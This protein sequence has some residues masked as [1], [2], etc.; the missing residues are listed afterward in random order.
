MHMQVSNIK[1]TTTWGWGSHFEERKWGM[2][3]PNYGRG[4]WYECDWDQDW[5]F[6]LTWVF[7]NVPLKK[8]SCNISR[9]WLSVRLNRWIRGDHTSH[10]LYNTVRSSH[11]R[12]TQSTTAMFCN[13]QWWN[14]AKN[15]KREKIGRNNPPLSIRI[16][17]S[18]HS[19]SSSSQVQRV[20]LCIS[21]SSMHCYE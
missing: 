9:S 17:P 7:N 21:K 8:Q 4:T 11:D 13:P 15:R 20:L 1:W 18:S 3:Q 14:T 10:A 12:E 5:Y 16:V 19:S 6:M 2:R